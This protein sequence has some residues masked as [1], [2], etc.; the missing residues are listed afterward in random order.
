MI[1]PDTARMSDFTLEGARTR[2][3]LAEKVTPLLA[4][5]VEKVL[6]DRPDDVAA[7]LSRELGGGG[8]RSNASATVTVTATAMASEVA[9]AATLTS[10]GI[11]AGIDDYEKD[12]AEAED[13]SD[14]ELMRLLLPDGRLPAINHPRISKFSL[15]L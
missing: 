9:S 14:G 5:V 4:P 10:S 1:E 12:T 7:F 8:S 3:F 13:I 11:D 15:S 2:Q 6:L